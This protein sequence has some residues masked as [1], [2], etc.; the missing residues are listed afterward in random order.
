MYLKQVQLRHTPGR[1]AKAEETAFIT[2][3]PKIYQ[4][5]LGQIKMWHTDDSVA[6]SRDIDLKGFLSSL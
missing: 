1:V 2:V 5:Y 4:E 6:E 3:L